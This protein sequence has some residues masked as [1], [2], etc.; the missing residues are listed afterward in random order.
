MLRDGVEEAVA[1]GNDRDAYW[2]ST[3]GVS[4]PYRLTASSVGIMRGLLR[5]EWMRWDSRRIVNQGSLGLES[6]LRLHRKENALQQ[7]SQNDRVQQP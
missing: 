4:T 3:L 1:Y 2:K 6:D 7:S 5:E